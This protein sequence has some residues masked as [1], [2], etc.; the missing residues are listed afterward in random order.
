MYMRVCVCMHM[1]IFILC[2]NYL[3]IHLEI[4]EVFP[5]GDRESCCHLFSQLL[6][7]FGSLRS[8]DF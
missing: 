7:F 6:I 4:T 5:K 8:F 2:V 1:V 3:L